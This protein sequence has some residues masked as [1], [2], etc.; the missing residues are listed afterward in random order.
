MSLGGGSHA[1]GLFCVC[2]GRGIQGGTTGGSDAG[3]G[4]AEN[5]GRRT[6]SLPLLHVVL[7]FQLRLPGSVQTCT[8]PALLDICIH[9]RPGPPCV[10]EPGRL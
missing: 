5:C 10:Q 4:L 7:A 2:V 9:G 6:L 8:F 1:G 3:L